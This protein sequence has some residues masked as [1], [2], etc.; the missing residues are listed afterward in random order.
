MPLDTVM[1]RTIAIGLVIY[2]PGPRLLSRLQLALESGFAVYVF[3][4]SPQ[5][6]DVREFCRNRANCTYVTCGKN[7]GLGIGISA[8]CAQAYY[9]SHSALLFFD[10]DTVFRESTLVF[11]ENFY[12]QNSDLASSY[13]AIVF[14]AAKLDSARNKG[15]AM[16]KDV[17]MAIS[18]GSLFFLDN[19][20]KLNWHNERYFVDCV[21]YE[22]CLNSSN[23]NLKIGECSITPG[24][25][26]RS[27]QPDERYLIFGKERLIRKYSGRRILD[28]LSASA[29]LIIT[30]ITT[31]NRRFL[32]G[33]VRSVSI[34]VTFQVLV[35]LIDGLGLKKWIVR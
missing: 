9:D 4:N 14:N 16:V 19:L 23:N 6:R 1:S 26:H 20:R 22:F 12:K 2:Q 27:E 10:Q 24:F 29:R 3:D 33:M 11:I 15:E 17:L 7:L 18:S 13:S 8:V 35:R 34:Y 28:T 25:D 21:D 30:S 32:V 31:G 5:K